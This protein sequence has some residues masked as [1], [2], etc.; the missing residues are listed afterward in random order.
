MIPK[1]QAAQLIVDSISLMVINVAAI[2][3]T[4]TNYKKQELLEAVIKRLN[5]IV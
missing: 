3:E 5:E 4:E 1:E 2:T